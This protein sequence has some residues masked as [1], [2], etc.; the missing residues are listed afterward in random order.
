MVI[1]EALEQLPADSSLVYGAPHQTPDGATVIT[2]AR[3]GGLLRSTTRP[4]G[5][6]VIHDGQATWT[7]AVDDTRIA[8]L[9]ETIGLLAAVIFTLTFLRRP[10]WPDLSRE[11]MMRIT[12]P[13]LWREPSD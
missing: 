13:R 1:R 2:V 9:A 4:V 12:H 8:L 10:P 11:V 6:F 5:V 7:P 3:V